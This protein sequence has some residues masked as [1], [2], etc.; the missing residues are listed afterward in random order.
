M[1]NTFRMSTENNV[2]DATSE[3]PRVFKFSPISHCPY[4]Y[5][6]PSPYAWVDTARKFRHPTAGFQEIRLRFDWWTLT[7]QFRDEMKSWGEDRKKI[8]EEKKKEHCPIC[9][10]SIKD[11]LLTN[12]AHLFCAQCLEM[13]KSNNCPLCRQTLNPSTFYFCCSIKIHVPV[14]RL[15]LSNLTL[16]FSHENSFYFSV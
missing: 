15:K 3:T 13:T 7:F 8:I 10:D 5:P 4:L 1:L 16:K 14:K 12:C 9:L 11:P 6:L 2:S